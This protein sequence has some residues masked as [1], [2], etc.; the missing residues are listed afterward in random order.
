M[1][2]QRAYSPIEA[3]SIWHTNSRAS[4]HVTSDINNLYVPNAYPDPSKLLVGNGEGLYISN[5][6][7][8][9]FHT[10]SE[11]FKLSNVLHVPDI[12]HNIIL[13]YQII[14]DNNCT[15]VCTPYSSLLRIHM[16]KFYTK[17]NQKVGSIQSNLV[18]LLL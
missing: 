12:S 4:N 1:A 18:Q 16:G 11:S 3:T 17:D 10:P 7:S 15:N 8:S 9:T 2:L 5:T 13:G 14:H 6:C